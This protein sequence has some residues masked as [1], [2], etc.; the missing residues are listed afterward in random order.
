[1]DCSLPGSSVYGILQA[2]MLEWGAI[3]SSRGSFQPRDQTWVYYIFTTSATWEA[4]EYKLEDTK[5]YR[6]ITPD[7]EISWSKGT[8]I[9]QTLFSYHCGI[10]LEISIKRYLKITHIFLSTV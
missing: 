6:G 7:A 10:M 3:S 1:M 9:I 8:E 2:R 5:A 4:L